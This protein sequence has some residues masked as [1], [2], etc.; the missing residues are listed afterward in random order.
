M[1]PCHVRSLRGSCAIP[2]A[3]VEQAQRPV[4][5]ARQPR[6]R[7]RQRRENV[8]RPVFS[9]GCLRIDA[10]ALVF[11][12]QLV[13][14]KF[15]ARG[16]LGKAALEVLAL[17]LRDG[18]ALWVDHRTKRDNFGIGLKQLLDESV[19]VLRRVGEGKGGVQASSCVHS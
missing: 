11:A 16:L 13:V 14:Q 6:L 9:Q 7:F 5:A 1:D 10:A 4:V 12:T 8:F 19:A 17:A 18:P 3:A 15:D 2:R